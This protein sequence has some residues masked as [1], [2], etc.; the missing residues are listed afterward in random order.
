M[1]SALIAFPVE[2]HMKVPTLPP[3]PLLN[4]LVRRVDVH[5]VYIV[6][7]TII[8]FSSVFIPRN[9]GPNSQQPVDQYVTI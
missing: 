4:F 2:T 9:F 7:K 3:F 1:A 8:L 5:I 6:I